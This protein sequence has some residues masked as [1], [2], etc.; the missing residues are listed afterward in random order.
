[1][2]GL[3][4]LAAR[5]AAGCIQDARVRRAPRPGGIFEAAAPEIPA[6]EK[7]RCVALGTSGVRRQCDEAKSLAQTYVRRLAT[8]DEVCLKAASESPRPADVWPE[9]SWR[10]PA[11]TRC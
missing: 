4:L 11:P 2:R 9:R 10:T 8:T 7:D 6:P 3:V 5:L 1:V